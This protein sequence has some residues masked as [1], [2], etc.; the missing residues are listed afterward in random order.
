[1]PSEPLPQILCDARAL[2]GRPAASVEVAWKL[3]E[4]GR[5]LDANLVRLPPG[6]RI[7]T[8]TEPDLDVLVTVVAGSGTVDTPAGG[9]PQDLAPGTVLWLPHGSTRSLTAGEQ[10]IAYFTVHSRRPGMQ[11]RPRPAA[12]P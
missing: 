7:A 1:M 3:A 11:I 8:H 5:Q 9:G 10:G 6:E 4:S 12:T 2:T